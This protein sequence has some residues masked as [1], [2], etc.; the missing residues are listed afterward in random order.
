MGEKIIL[1]IALAIMLIIWL[2]LA[3]GVW[4]FGF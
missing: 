2:V 3:V 1:S 4:K